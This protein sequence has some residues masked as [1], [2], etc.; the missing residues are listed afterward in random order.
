[1]NESSTTARLFEMIKRM[2]EDEQ[3]ALLKELGERLSKGRRKH[4]REPFFMVADYSAEDRVYRDYIQNVSAGGVF[5]ETHMPFTS[6]QEVSLAFPL[7]NYKKY[8]K[9]IGEVARVTPQ[10]IGVV[11]KMVNQEQETM[12]KSLLEWLTSTKR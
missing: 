12:V 7:P 1:M 9:I 3:L 4:E 8:I 6:G 5:I 11:F 2:P 10:G